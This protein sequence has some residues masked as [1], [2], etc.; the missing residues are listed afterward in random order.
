MSGR[1]A[2]ASTFVAGQRVVPGA[3]R[4]S[5]DDVWAAG[6]S[7]VQLFSTRVA[8]NPHSKTGRETPKIEGLGRGGGVEMFCGGPGARFPAL[9]PIAPP[10]F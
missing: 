5:P 6:S 3:A 4:A 8:G 10:R 2:L 1:Y 9:T 7:A